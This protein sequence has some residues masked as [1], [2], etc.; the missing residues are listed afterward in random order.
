MCNRAK[1]R[2][3]GRTPPAGRS[4]FAHEGLPE[5]VLVVTFFERMTW[6][7]FPVYYFGNFKFVGSL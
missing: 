4:A 5:R 3:E 2:K 7:K 6:K 1:R